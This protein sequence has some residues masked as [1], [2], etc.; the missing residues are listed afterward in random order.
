MKKV[1]KNVGM[2]VIFVLIL[3]LLSGCG[4]G[5]PD[6]NS[7]MY[8]GTTATMM[9]MTMDVSEVYENGVTFDLQDGGKCVANLDGEEVKLKWSTDGDKIHI[10]GGGVELDGTIGD[11]DLFIE[12]MMDMGMDLNLHCDALLHADPDKKT[13]SLSRGDKES[14]TEDHDEGYV[15]P[16]SVLGRLKDAKAGKPVYVLTGSYDSDGSF[17][18]S[19][20]DDGYDS[21]DSNGDDA[22]KNGGGPG[23]WA[24]FDAEESWYNPKNKLPLTVLQE[25]EK[26]MYADMQ[27]YTSDWTPTPTY[28]EIRDNYFNG[29][30]GEP[31]SY[32]AENFLG[33]PSAGCLWHADIEDGSAYISVSFTGDS[34]GVLRLEDYVISDGSYFPDSPR[35]TE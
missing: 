3:G 15:A 18:S 23:I 4:K 34:E 35:V 26:K 19:D 7:G 30:D 11:G 5:E 8:E 27:K 9:G 13:G 10:E 21:G 22:Q 17:F 24:D 12:N 25:A 6:P 20:S 31:I 16:E 28:E 1:R 33:D 14:D 29:V 2:T 32:E